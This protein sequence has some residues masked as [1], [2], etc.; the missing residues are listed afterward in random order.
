MTRRPLDAVAGGDTDVLRDVREQLRASEEALQRHQML[1]RL[2]GRL[3]RIGAWSVELPNFELTV[4]DEVCA[5]LEVAPG[6]SPTM[7]QANRFY[8][9]EHHAI[10]AEALEAC[11]RVG[12]PFDVEVQLIT[13]GGRRNLGAL[14][15]R[16]RAG[17]PG[18]IRRIQG[19]FKDIVERKTAEAETRDLTERLTTTLERLTA[20]EALRTSEERFRLL[21]SATNDAIWDWDLVTNALW[22]NEGFERL[23]GIGARRWVDHRVVDDLH[24]SGGSDPCD[25]RDPPRH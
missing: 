12:T 17:C 24:S 1:L 25:G 3:S 9:A 10:I 21:A 5:L 2:A 6:F 13:T 8:A 20:E 23:F 18:H 22:W 15:R 16:G 7:E 4:S 11:A 19:A 14:H